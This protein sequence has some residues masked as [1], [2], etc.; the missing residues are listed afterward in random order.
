MSARIAVKPSPRPAGAASCSTISHAAG[1]EAARGWREAVRWGPFVE[2][3]IRDAATVRA[4]LAA[5]RPDLV[6]HF[7]AYAY[8]GE[9]VADPALYY[10][11]NTAGTLA[12]L[13]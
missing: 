5:H 6:A 8:V 10:A 2:G 7:A 11:N 4:A 9:S 12:L 13:E 3:D 1:G